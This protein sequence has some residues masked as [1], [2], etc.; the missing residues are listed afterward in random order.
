M[1][2]TIGGTDTAKESIENLLCV[3]QMYF[4][5]QSID[6]ENLLDTFSSPSL[7]STYDDVIFPE[8]MR[9]LFK[10]GMSDGPCGCSSLQ[11]LA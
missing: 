7:T 10:C 11:S 2:E 5:G 8:R 9:Y 4:P 3:K 6:W 1:I